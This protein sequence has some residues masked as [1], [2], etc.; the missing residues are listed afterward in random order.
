[1][2]PPVI[3]VPGL[4]GSGSE[5]W[6]SRWQKR[7]PD[8]D[9]LEQADWD[10]P[11]RA[12]WI[13]RLDV[14]VARAKSPP[15]LV[16]HSLGCSLVACW[17]AASQSPVHAALLVGTPDIESD[18]HTP[19]ETH[20]FRPLPMSRLPFRTI[21]VA[22]RNDPYVAFERAAAMAEAWGAELV[23]VGNAGH[24]NTTAGYGEWPEGE[25]LLARLGVAIAAN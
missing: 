23:D 5:H 22:S 25:K 24:I 20:V 12:D 11:D 16:A 7:L 9:R 6:Q 1:M 14:A 8:V 13:A 18:V 4:A 3:I 17:A 10:N 19:P 21:V 2:S 15:I